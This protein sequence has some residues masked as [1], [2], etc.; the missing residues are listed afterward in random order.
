VQIGELSSRKWLDVPRNRRSR[1]EHLLVSPASLGVQTQVVV[2]HRKV[3][4]GFGVVWV[5][6]QRRFEVSARFLKITA[7]M[8]DH[9]KHVVQIGVARGKPDGF[10]QVVLR[11]RIL[12]FCIVLAGQNQVLLEGIIH[13]STQPPV[14]G[15]AEVT[16]PWGDSPETAP[17]GRA[18]IGPMNCK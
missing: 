13:T 2:R 10:D 1:P 8:V 5:D 12:A 17:P 18:G 9:P 11:K 7:V 14:R 16:A 15:V 4:R 6:F 3:E